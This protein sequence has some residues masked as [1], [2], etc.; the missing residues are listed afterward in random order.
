MVT[1]ACF[2][3]NFQSDEIAIQGEHEFLMPCD[4]ED[5]SKKNRP[6]DDRF[7]G[8]GAAARWLDV[9]YCSYGI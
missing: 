6:C 1:P 9:A 2:R 7:Q 5:G 3:A 8:F 4:P